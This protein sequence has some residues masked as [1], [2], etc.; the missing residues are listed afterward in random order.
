M[1][2]HVVPGRYMA[3]DL[4][5]LNSLETLEGSRLSVNTT[6]GVVTVDGATVI[7]SDTSGLIVNRVRGDEDKNRIR[8][9]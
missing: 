2:Y 1:L 7:Q 3:S 9:P 4:V 5:Q 6:N 8:I